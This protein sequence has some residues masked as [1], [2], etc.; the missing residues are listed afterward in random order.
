MANDKNK[1]NDPEKK[2]RTNPDLLKNNIQP[3]A[4]A[5]KPPSR[6]KS[7][8][9]KPLRNENMIGGNH[10]ERGKDAILAKGRQSYLNTVDKKLG[11]NHAQQNNAHKSNV[12]HIVPGEIGKE[13]AKKPN[14]MKQEVNK[15]QN[16]PQQI[17]KTVAPQ[18]QQT[19]N[20]QQAVPKPTQAK[21]NPMKQ[22]VNRLQQ[23]PKPTKQAKTPTKTPT[24]GK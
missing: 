13:E 9:K 16:S 14:P 20:K 19:Q 10:P 15:L 17:S 3:N 24:K 1:S 4:P 8:N 11:T 21:D 23:A 12:K 22:E 5:Q 6:A 18:K 2:K 7:Q